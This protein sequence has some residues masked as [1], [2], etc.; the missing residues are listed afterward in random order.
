L[1]VIIVVIWKKLKKDEAGDKE[2]SGKLTM[3][4]GR[5]SD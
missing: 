3:Q 4:E 1:G 2:F 5:P